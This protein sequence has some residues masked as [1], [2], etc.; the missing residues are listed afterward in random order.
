MLLH[1]LLSAV[2]YNARI[3]I[4]VLFSANSSSNMSDV[5]KLSCPEETDHP[6]YAIDLEFKHKVHLVPMR[7]RHDVSVIS[8]KPEIHPII[9]L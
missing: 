8:G 7:T 1:S 9:P 5:K 6:S 3:R 2:S 4:N